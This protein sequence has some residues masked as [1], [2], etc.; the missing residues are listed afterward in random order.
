[1]SGVL[2]PLLLCWVLLSPEHPMD[3]GLEEHSATGWPKWAAVLGR[4]QPD[5]SHAV[6]RLHRRNFQ[7]FTQHEY[8]LQIFFCRDDAADE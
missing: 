2:L 7:H 3:Q 6:A 8:S 5:R 1:M 4:Q